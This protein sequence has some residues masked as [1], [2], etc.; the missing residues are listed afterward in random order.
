MGCTLGH[1]AWAQVTR[2]L[3]EPTAAAIAYGLHQ[4][5]NVHHIMVRD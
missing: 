3:E 4:K 2:V 1:V 5:P